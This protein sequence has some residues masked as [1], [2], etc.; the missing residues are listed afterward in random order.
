MEFSDDRGN[1]SIEFLVAAIAL[2]VPVVALTVTT[3]EIASATF[4]ATVAARQGV[5]AF[6]L[7][8]TA[9]SG[10]TAIAD[11]TDLAVADHGLTDVDWRIELDCA[12]R[13]CRQRGSLVSLEV[14]IDVPLRFIPALPGI[15]IAPRVTVSRSATTRVS[16]TSVNR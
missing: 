6:T 13:S 4:A 14:S 3:S 1:A 9:A 5:R 8:D 11:I 16:T 10:Q 12:G 2:L 15:D 7:A